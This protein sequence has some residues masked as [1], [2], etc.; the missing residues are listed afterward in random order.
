MHKRCASCGL[1]FE[2]EQ[3]YFLGA[4]YVNY[5]FTVAVVI[6]GY[7]FLEAWTEMTLAQ[8]L[9]LWGSVSLLCP[10]LLFRQ[11]RGL[12]LSFDYIFH[13]VPDAPPGSDEEL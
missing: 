10:L 4:M 9:T 13:P 8:Q 7:F 5:A 6:S 2:R 12:W 1:Q 3:G 11:A